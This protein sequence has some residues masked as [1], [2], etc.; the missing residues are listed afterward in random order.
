MNLWMILKSMYMNVGARQVVE[1]MCLFLSISNSFSP[2]IK[3]QIHQS[4]TYLVSALLKLL[5]SLLSFCLYKIAHSV[6]NDLEKKCFHI[7]PFNV[8]SSSASFAIFFLM[9][10]LQWKSKKQTPRFSYLISYKIKSWQVRI[11][12]GLNKD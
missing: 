9:F 5:L 7:K 12:G 6:L 11:G 4:L 2:Y 8:Q 1:H 10:P 3:Y